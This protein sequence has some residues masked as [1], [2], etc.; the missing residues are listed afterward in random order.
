MTAN[1]CSNSFCD[2]VIHI[3]A[4]C[5]FYTIVSK[6]LLALLFAVYSFVDFTFFCVFVGLDMLINSCLP[7]FSRFPTR[8]FVGKR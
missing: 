8:F 7:L 4:L 6:V 2:F 1:D 5:H 3:V